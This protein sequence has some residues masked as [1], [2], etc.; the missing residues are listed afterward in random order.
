MAQTWERLLF[1]HWPVPE[2][3]LRPLVPPG[4]TLQ[5]FDGRAWLGITPF[6]LSG[7]RLRS[8]PSLRGLAPFPELNVRTYVT[9]DDRPG[10]FFFSLD[11][12]SA[13]AVAG[14][15]RLY[16]LPYFR[17][18]FTVT[19]G[20]TGVAYRCRRT[21]RGA[22][23]A[24]FSAAYRPIG[25]IM[26]WA[27]GTLVH[28]LTERY[29]LYAVTRAGRLRRAEIHH[30]VW[31]LQCAEVDIRLN[32]MTDGLGIQ[33]AASDPVVHFAERL[34]VYVWPPETLGDLRRWRSISPR[35]SP[36]ASRFAP[37]KFRMGQVPVPFERRLI[38]PAPAR[39]RSRGAHEIARR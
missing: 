11:A 30:P 28:W 1:A 6:M 37:T 26:T 32:S 2:E 14:A 36:D 38:L 13:L 15:R 29:C 16:S 23:P 39:P 34:E 22:P 3:K 27:P 21:H 9:L 5:T 19:S 4:L 7:L 10:V 31:P 24:E 33:L 17:A 25:P 35:T 8:L 18:R 20:R 12:A